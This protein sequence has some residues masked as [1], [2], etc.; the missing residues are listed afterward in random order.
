MRL[1]PPNKRQLT[2]SISPG[3]EALTLSSRLKS[4][5]R[6]ESYYRRRLGLLGK[7]SFIRMADST[8]R[9]AGDC[10]ILKT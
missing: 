4:S 10:A 3:L 8:T 2:L 5:V 6:D 9:L 7:A 1:N